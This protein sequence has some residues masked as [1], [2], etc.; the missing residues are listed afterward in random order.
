MTEKNEQKVVAWAV[1][2]PDGRVRY[3]TV[4][5]IGGGDALRENDVVRP[6]VYGDTGQGV[7]WALLERIRNDKSWR[8]ND[9]ALWTDICKALASKPTTPPL[10]ALRALE[11]K[12]R[13]EAAIAKRSEQDAS[14]E[15]QEALL[16]GAAA[17]YEIAADE[18]AA[19][20]DQEKNDGR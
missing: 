19:A 11:G 17:S 2:A 6:L 7:A 1:V 5:D 20:L 3:A 8:T 10:D 13:E 4:T 14:S 16:I 15:Y 18:L 9:N 12:W